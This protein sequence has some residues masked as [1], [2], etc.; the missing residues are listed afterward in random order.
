MSRT[1]LYLWPD[2]DSKFDKKEN[3]Y[4]VL[5]IKAKF[6]SHKSAIQD[7][8]YII[9]NLAK[10]ECCSALNILELQY[11]KIIALHL[12]GYCNEFRNCFLSNGLF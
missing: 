5:I 12:I 4:E 7:Q 11:S 6:S 9:I 2:Y 1:K 3:Y 8:R 10:V